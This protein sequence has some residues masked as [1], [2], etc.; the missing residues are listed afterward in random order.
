MVWM[1]SIPSISGWRK[2]ETTTG[3]LSLC[4]EERRYSEERYSISDEAFCHSFCRHLTV[5]NDFRPSNVAIDACQQ[6]ASSPFSDV[7]Q[8]GWPNESVLNET[9]C[10]MKPSWGDC[11]EC[12][13]LQREASLAPGAESLSLLSA[14]ARSSPSYVLCFVSVPLNFKGGGGRDR[15]RAICNRAI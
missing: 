5:G 13:I 15:L 12:K 1:R 8:H 4:G 2:D 10:G 6:E 14:I 11:G 3:G 9:L 7:L